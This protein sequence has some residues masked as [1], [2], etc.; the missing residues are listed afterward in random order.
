M[1]VPILYQSKLYGIVF[2]KSIVIA[3]LLTITGT[4]GT[5]LMFLLENHVIGGRS[6]YG[7]VFFVPL[8]FLVV[9]KCLNIKYGLLMDLCA[10][11]ECLMLALMKVLCIISGCCAGRVLCENIAGEAVRFPSQIVE[12]IGALVVAVILLYI[13]SQ[14][15]YIAR[16]YP[17]YL[18]LYGVSRFVLNF[19]REE[20]QLWKWGNILPFGTLWSLVALMMGGFLLLYLKKNEHM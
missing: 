3:V 16:L 20:W 11:A 4:V 17:W 12:L 9:A 13:F 14:K 10:P 5:Y 8:A 7:A 2:W 6:F 18:F 1:L 19:M 15:K